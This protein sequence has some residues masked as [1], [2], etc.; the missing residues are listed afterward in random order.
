MTRV[1]WV[2]AAVTLFG[3][4]AA[5]WSVDWVRSCRHYHFCCGSEQ[6]IQPQ[7]DVTSRSIDAGTVFAVV[8]VAEVLQSEP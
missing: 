8:T 3:G 6:G 1:T 4:M 2:L 5:L 7:P